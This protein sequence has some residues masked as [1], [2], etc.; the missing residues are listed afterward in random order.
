VNTAAINNAGSYAKG[1][2]AE[3]KPDM[4][5]VVVA[6]GEH[7]LSPRQIISK[8]GSLKRGHKILDHWVVM[9]RQRIAKEMLKLAPPVGSKVKLK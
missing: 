7:V 1:G 4:A 2:K 5:P 9:E 6:G 3:S 8:F